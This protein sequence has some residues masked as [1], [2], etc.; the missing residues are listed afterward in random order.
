M[1]RKL[2][3]LLRQTV[4]TK[5][6]PKSTKPAPPLNLI[7]RSQTNLSNCQSLSQ[8]GSKLLSKRKVMMKSMRGTV[9][10]SLKA[11]FMNYTRMRRLMW[12]PSPNT[13]Y[14]RKRTKFRSLPEKASQ[15][16]KRVRPL[17]CWG[18]YLPEGIRLTQLAYPPQLNLILSNLRMT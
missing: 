3:S 11:S 8:K 12:I 17:A 18:L 1:F 6:S 5:K 15:S 9:W 16:R 13:W 2:V 10:N 7:V 14:S 4:S